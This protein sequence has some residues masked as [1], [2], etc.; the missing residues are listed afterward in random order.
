MCSEIIQGIFQGYNGTIFAYGQTG[1]GKTY[2]MGTL[3]PISN[4][5]QEGIISLSIQDIFRQKQ[6]YETQGASITV[7][8]SYLEIYM[9]KCY[10]LLDNTTRKQLEV[11]GTVAEG[12]SQHP[13]D[14]MDTLVE[15]LNVAAKNRATGS[16]S[17][18][19][20]S[21]RSHAICS[22][23][24]HI[25][26]GDT[27]SDSNNANKKITSKLNLVDLAGSERYTTHPN[28]LFPQSVPHFYTF[29][30]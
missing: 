28:T 29:F 11:R 20:Q 10:D 25:D 27:P 2:T 13:I 6:E 9:E 5:L 3:D 12:L 1:S 22:I 26:Y 24:L 14:S 17:M 4:T 7:Q 19:A 16:T 23:T 21:S 18:N 8:L 30:Y 15:Y